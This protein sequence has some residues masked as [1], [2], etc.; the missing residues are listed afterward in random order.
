MINL[1]KYRTLLKKSFTLLLL[2]IAL[3]FSGFLL[4]YFPLSLGFGLHLLFGN[5]L[6]YAF[7]RIFSA[8]GIT[9][10][11]SIASLR[12]VFLWNHPWAWAIWTLEAAVVARYTR[13]LSPVL[14]D[15]IFWVAIGA[16]LL[17]LSYGVLLGTDSLT[18][19]LVIAKQVTNGV[20]N[21]VA[22]ELLYFLFLLF[23]PANI[24]PLMPKMPLGSLIVMVMLAIM[25]IPPIALLYVDMPRDSAIA[26]EKKLQELQADLDTA[27][28]MLGL[29]AV[30]RSAIL[31]AHAE[32]A[33]DAG[34]PLDRASED[35]L[36]SDFCGI[37][38]STRNGAAVWSG[39]APHCATLEAVEF[40]TASIDHHLTGY[41]IV[42]LQSQ[43]STSGSR[44]ALLVPFRKNGTEG[45]IVAAFRQDVMEDLL[46]RSSHNGSN[47]FFIVDPATGYVPLFSDNPVATTILANQIAKSG[48][49]SGIVPISRYVDPTAPL[50]TA[51]PDNWAVLH[52]QVAS[53][54]GRNLFAATSLE[55]EIRDIRNDQSRLFVMLCS[56]IL[57]VALLA[58]LIKR[59][60]GRSLRQ[61][62][63]SAATLAV[64]GVN[65]E[66]IDSL[67]VKE[68]DDISAIIDSAGSR[69]ARQNGAL[70]M[71]QR[72]LEN[73][74]K[75]APLVIYAIN[76]TDGKVDGAIYVSETI[77]AMLGFEPVDVSSP[78]WWAKA[79]H[80]DDYDH[81]TAAFERL[82]PNKII[83]SEYRVRHKLGHYIWVY[84]KLSI[85]RA[86]NHGNLE[87][88]GVLIDITERKAATNQLIQA[89]KMASLGRI[90]TGTAHELNQPLN[91]I[92]LA[93]S[94]LS[95][96]IR[97]GQLDR[98]SILAKL[99]T[100]LAQVARASDIMLHMRFF[101]RIPKEAEQP[102][103]VMTSMRAVLAMISPQLALDA[104]EVD[105]SACQGGV[106]VR[107]H[108]ILLEQ[109][110]MNILLNANDAILEGG[111][112]GE[113]RDGL[114]KISVEQKECH[115]VITVED[116]GAG[117][118]AE[119]LPRLYEAFFTTKPPKDGMGLGLSVSVEIIHNI[120]GTIEAVSALS[121]AKF[122]LKIPIFIPH[123][124]M[125]KA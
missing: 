14:V 12:T 115:A 96:R 74:T 124:V 100:I 70:G 93:A 6:I 118:K 5:A 101:G 33:V 32:K 98:S 3:G 75:H 125:K 15:V 88:V 49:V 72:R 58:A 47:D 90:L 114:I 73:L 78:G 102:I 17:A 19:V 107:A 28:T 13:R 79:V 69:A 116:N 53:L 91:L 31:I 65:S 25:L 38:F 89:E 46:G 104:T 29:W 83:H 54:P 37:G 63:S 113:H 109:V 1:S 52:K 122:V 80:P 111:R 48:A 26:E 22:G 64:H 60:V 8:T 51:V 9:V 30:S 11:V 66:K 92:S 50:I 20:F 16:P 120:G 34:I 43:S 108:P 110:F 84:D 95:E 62:A 119:D 105:S 71:Y 41:R 23:K 82:R 44:L 18:L 97:I 81:Y 68:L 76:I 7:L 57:L 123:I 61:L 94:N 36:A 35:A 117:I 10:A 121:G 103:D 59:W 67:V 24:R 21:V 112:T 2:A 42:S 39:S 99:N 4:N 85:E 77:K 27:E 55:Q 106:T 56:A 87:G 86:V 40:L 45:L